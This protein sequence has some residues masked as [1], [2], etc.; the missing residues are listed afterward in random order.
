M[1]FEIVTDVAKTDFSSDRVFGVIYLEIMGVAFPGRGWTDFVASILSDWLTE[2]SSGGNCKLFFYD[3]YAYIFVNDQH[4]ELFDD[5]K[6]SATFKIGRKEFFFE[7]RRAA[8]KFFSEM[9]SNRIA[10]KD[11]DLKKLQAQCAKQSGIW[12]LGD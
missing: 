1:K 7:I 11:R 3:C 12:L 4:V 5:G 8:E 9:Q 6:L 10:H 2:E